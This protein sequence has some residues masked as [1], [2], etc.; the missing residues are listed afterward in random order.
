MHKGGDAPARRGGLPRDLAA[1]AG[2]GKAAPL[3]ARE[4]DLLASLRDSLRAAAGESIVSATN[5]EIL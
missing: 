2:E 4:L 3:L 1:L 5:D